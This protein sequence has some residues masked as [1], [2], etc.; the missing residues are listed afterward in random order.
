MIDIKEL[1]KMTVK[2]LVDLAKK[3]GIFGC[4]QWRKNELIIALKKALKSA[5]SSK[6]KSATKSKST[7]KKASSSVQ[8]SRT[9]KKSP[10][11]PKTTAK[12][13]LLKSLA[14]PH[15]TDAQKPK[16]VTTKK[17]SKKMP[18]SNS[19]TGKLSAKTP[20]KVQ[21]AIKTKESPASKAKVPLPKRSTD[22]PVA[23]SEADSIS[24]RPTQESTVKSLELQEDTSRKMTEL[25][26]SLFKYRELSGVFD[27]GEH[28]D[29]LVLMA[30]DS[31]WLHALWELN[32][33][34][35]ERAK[36]AM[37]AYWHTAVPIIRLYQI[38]ADGISKQR[39][40][41][42]R[43]IRLQGHVNN[44]YI[45]VTDPPASFIIE[46]G[47]VSSKGKFFPLASSNEVQTPENHSLSR[48]EGSDENWI[49]MAY[50]YDRSFRFD[51]HSQNGPDA[52]GVLDARHS[53]RPV[54]TPL[55]TRFGGEQLETVKVEI[56]ADV[57]I[58]GK[59]QPDVQLVIKNEPIRLQPDGR[60]SVRFHM[61][62][63]RQV[64]PIVA[65]SSDGIE[66]QTTIL[67]I[68]RNTKA[69]E[70]VYREH[71]DLD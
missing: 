68:E 45:D 67:A 9:A 17:T 49:G 4:S 63:K 29:R 56:E 15:K 25:K 26:D 34:L 51:R 53:R 11:A 69:L 50:E 54:P 14:S 59:T 6:K 36:A 18:T 55:I 43:D 38:V 61:P 3:N 57:I 28:V 5:R 10:P 21:K 13:T 46:V 24:A 30:R 32:A 41:H 62:E 27:D 33:K 65:V 39:R 2:Q 42:L 22:K 47:Y 44:W 58:Y 40:V 1:E 70:T 60:F 16:Q 7:T 52:S 71:D 19:K 8:K 66:S 64:Y 23:K 12:K 35:V 37:G 31:Y 48:S 20:S